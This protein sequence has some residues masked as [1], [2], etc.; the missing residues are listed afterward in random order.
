MF[1]YYYS[2]TF[3]DQLFQVLKYLDSQTNYSLCW[4]L[5][6]KIGVSLVST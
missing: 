1:Y 5:S 6:I 4:Y 2:M 3:D